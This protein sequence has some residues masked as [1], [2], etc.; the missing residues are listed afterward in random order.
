MKKVSA[1]RGHT[2]EEAAAHLF[3]SPTR[4]YELVGDRVIPRAQRSGYNLSRVRRAYCQYLRKNKTERDDVAGQSLIGART[5]LA[6]QQTEAVVRKNAITRSDFVPREVFRKHWR[7]TVDR[8]TTR[9]L[10]I[11]L[12]APALEMQE[13]AAV[14]EALRTE[15]HAALTDFSNGAR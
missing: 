15:I 9:A 8:V 5:A 14:A 4:F 6:Q 7:S 1:E 10:A 11:C 2:V 3:M 13:R 12:I